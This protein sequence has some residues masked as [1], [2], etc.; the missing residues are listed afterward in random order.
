MRG[1]TSAVLN[2]RAETEAG[3][4]KDLEHTQLPTAA[5]LKPWMPQKQGLG[6]QG[7][8]LQHILPL[9]GPARE[10]LLTLSKGHNTESS[11]SSQQMD[12]NAGG[13]MRG[14][15]CGDGMQSSKGDAGEQQQKPT[16]SLLQGDT[17][18]IYAKLSNYEQGC[19]RCTRSLGNHGKWDHSGTGWGRREGAQAGREPHN[20]GSASW[21]APLREDPPST[22]RA[23][24][25][26]CQ[27]CASTATSGN[28]SKKQK[29]NQTSFKISLPSSMHC[30]AIL[31]KPWF[32]WLRRAV[33]CPNSC[34]M[35]F[36]IC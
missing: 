11:C 2:C 18:E 9:C 5:P 36:T 21:E 31:P 29:Q 12:G 13:S 14:H 17:P 26:A 32:M 4:G 25:A 19:P 10:L 6:G 27:S 20:S 30:H 16:R 28:N 22:R 34:M 7:Y 3:A 8:L 35:D 33:S 1:R 24:W 23:Q 15:R